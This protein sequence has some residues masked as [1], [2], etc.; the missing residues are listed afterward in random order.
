MQAAQQ[1]QVRPGP[2]LAQRALSAL[3]A[4]VLRRGGQ[5]L[6]GG[7]RQARGQ[8][9]AAERARPGVLTPELDPGLLAAASLRRNA[10]AGSRKITSRCNSARNWPVVMVDAA[11]MITVAAAAAAVS[12]RALVSA[13]IT[14]ALAWSIRPAAS[15]F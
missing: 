6:V 9:T 2:Q 1:S 8:V 10:A 7:Q 11:R 13:T 15:A 14:A 3:R 4:K 5:V 12:P